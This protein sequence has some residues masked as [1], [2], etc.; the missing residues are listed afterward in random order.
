MATSQICGFEMGHASEADFS[1]SGAIS[2]QTTIKRNG[3]YALRANPSPS[4]G[5]ICFQRRPAGGTPNAIYQSVRFYMRVASLPSVNTVIVYAGRDG[6]GNSMGL[7][8][9]T[10]GKLSLM[11]QSTVRATSTNALTVDGLWHR[12]E[13]DCGWSAGAGM[14]V[15]VDGAQWAS[16]TADTGIVPYTIGYLGP[17]TT[18]TCDLYFDDVL[19]DSSTLGGARAN[20]YNVILLQPVADSIINSW[21]GGAGGTTNLWDALN[22]APPV[23]VVDPGT[24]TSQIRNVTKSA[25]PA[26]G[27][28][29][30]SYEEAGILTDDII[31]GVMAITNHAEGT[32]YAMGGNVWVDSNPN[33]GGSMQSFDFGNASGVAATF[34]SGWKT[35]TGVVLLNPSVVRAT[36]PVV[37]IGLQ[38]VNKSYARIADFLGIY[39]DYTPSGPTLVV[40]NAT[41]ATSSEAPVFTQV[42][43]LTLADGHHATVSDKPTNTYNLVVQSASHASSSGNVVVTRIFNL[44]IQ[45]ASHV[46]TSQSPV[47]IYNLIVGDSHHA[48]GSSN[49]VIVQTSLLVVQSSAHMVVDNFSAPLLAGSVF[50]VDA[51]QIAGIADG[52]ALYEWPDI[53][54]NGHSAFETGHQP[55]YYKTTVGKLSPTGL[56]MVWFD[57]ANMQSMAASGMPAVAYPDT[58]YIVGRFTTIATLQT[59]FDSYTDAEQA[60]SNYNVGGGYDKWDMWAP[61]DTNPGSI[62]A[63]TNFHVWA[64]VFNGANS[65]LTVDGVTGSGVNPGS[66]QMHGLYLGQQWTG[67][68]FNGPIAEVLVYPAAH[69][70]R[71]IAANVAALT[72]KWSAGLAGGLTQV[73]HLSVANS[74][75]AQSAGAEMLTQVHNLIVQNGVHA[76]TSQ[77]PVI[78]RIYNLVVADTA[79]V[80]SSE[81]AILTQ[82]YVLTI[83][84]ASH[85]QVAGA[86]T[87][88]QVHNLVVQNGI[89]ATS[90]Q[91]VAITQTHILTVAPC[92]H[93]QAVDATVLTQVHLL[94]IQGVTHISVSDNVVVTRIFNIVVQNAVSAIASEA[95]VFTQVHNLTV[96]NGVHATGSDA[97]GSMIPSVTCTWT[98]ADQDSWVDPS[99]GTWNF[100]RDG[101]LAPEP[102]KVIRSNVG[103]I[104]DL[105]TT[106]GQE[107]ALVSGG[108][109]LP[110]GVEGVVDLTRPVVSSSAGYQYIEGGIM[111]GVSDPN[112][113]LNFILFKTAEA[114]N[115]AKTPSQLYEFVIIKSVAGAYTAL[116]TSSSVGVTNITHMWKMKLRLVPSPTSG[117]GVVFAKAWDPSVV[118]EPAWPTS[119]PWPYINVTAA[120]VV[121]V[122]E[123]ASDFPTNLGYYGLW[124]YW[125]YDGTS[126]S[127]DFDNFDVHLHKVTNL[128]VQDSSHSPSSENISLSGGVATLTIQ[129][130]SHAT[131]SPNEVLT[132]VHNL[133]VA[134]ASHA[135]SSP[136]I[137]LTQLHILA[138][139]SASHATTVGAIVLTQV[140]I[141]TVVNGAHVT[142]SENAV[143]S[144]IFNLVIVDSPHA[145]T[146]ESPKPIYNEIVA[147]AASAVSSPNI[148]IAQ[149]HSLV[150]QSASHIQ[151][152]EATS[153]TQIHIL[154]VADGHHATIVEALTLTQ[155]HI[156]IVTDSHH[157]TNVEASALSQVHILTVQ[158][159]VHTQFAQD[160]ALQAQGSLTPLN[161]TNPVVSTTVEL[162][163]VH[164]LVV[165]SSAHGSTSDTPTLLLPYNLAVQ[166]SIHA[167]TAQAP[168]FTQVHAIFVNDSHHLTASANVVLARV[169]NLVVQGASHSTSNSVPPIGP[170]LVVQGSVQ[171]TASQDVS[172]TQVHNVVVANTIFATTSTNVSLSGEAN[173]EVSDSYQP[174]A[175]TSTTIS[176]LHRLVVDPSAHICV[177]DALSL[178][179]THIL[180]AANASHDVSSPNIRFISGAPKIWIGVSWQP[181][182]VQV[183]RETETWERV[184]MYRWTGNDWETV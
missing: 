7:R 21:T 155:L 120:S 116:A 131:S 59:I 17:Q 140:H 89:H 29:V 117:K 111:L 44:A 154:T 174:I 119:P 4:Y 34:P 178:I 5:Y 86:E 177:V 1:T 170:T 95:P 159:A 144:R 121:Q 122:V 90:S 70:P 37:S 35:C 169:F 105:T 23:G 156:L 175:S 126:Y 16:D 79:H 48:V 56:P 152:V 118:G 47:G 26:Y 67:A 99:S 6:S 83:Q 12:I 51:S 52:A 101:A 24:N 135:T 127:E 113:P 162:T 58:V 164:N 96:A 68:F 45:S 10:D 76:T 42:H 31:N 161:A 30:Q 50:H 114:S 143:L 123:M 110:P 87:L 146:S 61:D 60:L 160:C 166:S 179:Q 109:L 84:G 108:P 55:R 91:N 168:T 157:V 181:K 11:S 153:L 129:D 139:G 125:G 167:Q 85:T 88:T 150:V 77:A 57:P 183:Y 172:I 136:V 132:Q 165:Q 176:Q 180:T 148:V 53:S 18:C 20:D 39:V 92:A 72:T 100:V 142:A 151:T 182:F 141:L 32:A 93:A 81:N 65:S 102:T 73:H 63:D 66:N 64:C 19:W 98:H 184:L 62:P 15:Y 46:T 9:N 112:S 78:A 124:S 38:S 82:N 54:G 8:L 145:L 128:V 134:S 27:A 103:R 80:S 2:V 40:A 149:V 43:S 75:H 69:T 22:N 133:T 147:D 49:V 106:P 71:E 25:T 173:L 104:T 13:F 171:A 115:G 41:H 97:I 94:T 36:R 130:A 138:V 28:S 107:F 163:Q 3:S 14:R 74:A 158:S 33:G 137:G